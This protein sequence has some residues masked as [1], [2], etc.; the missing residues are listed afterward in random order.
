VRA[1][2]FRR[3]GALFAAALF[4]LPARGLARESAE[5]A[6]TDRESETNL[7]FDFDLFGD[8]T[9]RSEEDPA[10]AGRARLRRGMLQAHQI[11]GLTTLGLMA[12][13]VVLGQLNF[14][15]HF[16]A[17]GAGS[18]A[19]STPHRIAAYS[20]AAAFAV[21]GGLALLAPVPYEKAPG[22]DAGTV[23][24]L[25]AFGAVAGMA[26]QVALGMIAGDALRSGQARRFESVA[27]LHRFTGYATL[28][29]LATAAAAWLF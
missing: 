11:A 28:T 19:Y 12:T 17:S 1:P 21:T 3:L 10:L 27:D 29:L 13:T 23:H 14:D 2:I 6:A 15:D 5:A 18:G 20:T 22:F 4:A 24:K 25:A 9:K 26:G 16:S 8:G 7:D